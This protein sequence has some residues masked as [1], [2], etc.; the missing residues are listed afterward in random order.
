MTIYN[1]NCS[2]NRAR[3]I[4]DALRNKCLLFHAWFATLQHTVLKFHFSS[5][6]SIWEKWIWT[7]VALKMKILAEKKSS[8]VWIYARKLVKIELFELFCTFLKSKIWI[9]IRKF[10]YFIY[11]LGTKLKKKKI[12]ILGATIQ[13]SNR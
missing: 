12:P 6:N 10:N 8:T 4:G 7:F 11:I 3:K 2:N 1:R 5:K 9:L 13:N